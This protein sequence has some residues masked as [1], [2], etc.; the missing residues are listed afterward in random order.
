MAKVGI[1]TDTI[2]CLPRE[3]V[4]EYGIV[5]VPINVIF[6]DQVYQDEVD[7]T[8]SEVYRLL[9]EGKIPTTSAPSPGVYLEAYRELSQR[10]ESIV[11]ITIATELTMVYQSATQAREMAKEE[12]PHTTVEVIDSRTAAGSQG[13]ITLAAARAAAAG[14]SLDEVIKVTQDMI[15]RV[16]FLA[17]IDTLT[18]LAKHGR[19]PAIAAWAGSRLQI[20]PLLTVSNGKARPITAVRTKRRGVERLL[21]IMRQRTGANSPL[22][23]IVLHAN[24]LEEAE[25]LKQRIS[26]EFNCA[27][28]YVK[29]F[30]PVMGVHTGPGLLGAAFY[31]DN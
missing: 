5:I 30:T 10:V 4:E 31:A 25:S 14:Q 6:E 27:E 15:P 21:E 9:G 17:V 8:P 18:Y 26:E 20:K 28:I 23:V 13:L 19:V 3:L 11:C 1:I 12:L 7:I 2:A 29:D 22:H 16:H 24:V